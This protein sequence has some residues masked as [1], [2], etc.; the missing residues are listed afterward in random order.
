M[1]SDVSNPKSPKRGYKVIH[2]NAKVKVFD[3][4]IT[5]QNLIIKTI[6]W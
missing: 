5:K 1:N 2:L 3:F 4:I 6:D